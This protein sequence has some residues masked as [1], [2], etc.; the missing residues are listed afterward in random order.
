MK[1]RYN[2]ISQNTPLGKGAS[3]L[4]K[5]FTS[6]FFLFFAGMGTVF[7]VLLIKEVL[8]GKAEWPLIFFLIIPLIFVIIGFGGLYGVWFGKDKDKSKISKSRHKSKQMGKKG[9]LVFGAVFVLVGAG[10]SYWLLIHPLIKTYQAKS[11]VET[12]CRIISAQVGSHSSD[13]GT[14]YSIDITYQYQFNGATYTA[15]RYDFIGG[16]S[17]GHQG[18][19]EVVTRYKQM[20]NPVCFVNPQKPTEAVLMR[21]LTLKNAIGLFPLIFVAAGLFVM[22]NAL[23]QKKHK[24]M[25]W[26]PKMKAA[27]DEP[28]ENEY[29]FAGQTFNT[30]QNSITLKPES[31]P[32]GKLIAVIFFCLFWNGIVSVF[33]NEAFQAYKSGSPEWG[34]TLFM[35]PFVLI[36]LVLVGAVFYQLLAL[37]NPRYTLT[38]TPGRLHPGIAAAIEWNVRGKASRIDTLTIKLLGKE[39]ARYQVGTNTRTASNTFFEMDIYETHDYHEIVAGQI[40]F[41]I[42]EDTMHSFE[43]DSN[44]I[45]WSINVHGDIACWPDVKQVY[46]IT[47]SP[48]PVS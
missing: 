2:N 30:S 34:L 17:S 42:P 9:Q 47:I 4:S 22:I 14:T 32:L 20:P 33:V 11:W 46:K 1:F 43:A 8:S 21:K 29:A 39:E 3:V 37:F 19:Q 13:D 38:L 6:V 36:G 15:D 40:G 7:C 12:P 28:A 24:G 41:A 45:I 31:S 18:K 10:V 48:K 23:K 44:K 16:S 25:K 27:D 26:L 35:V 5:L